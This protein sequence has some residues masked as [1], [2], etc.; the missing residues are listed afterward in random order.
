MSFVLHDLV[1]HQKIL[2][3]HYVWK[4]GMYYCSC[5]C[6]ACLRYQFLHEFVSGVH[7]HIQ[8]MWYKSWEISIHL[9]MHGYSMLVSIQV[10]F[11]CL[12]SCKSK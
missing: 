11:V 2:M 10:C 4:E 7:M 8:S 3:G 9:Y 12:F 1:Y 6:M 5:S